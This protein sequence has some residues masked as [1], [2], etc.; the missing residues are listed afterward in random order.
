M[1]VDSFGTYLLHSQEKAK[2]FQQSDTTTFA[3][4]SLG[5]WHS[6]QSV[7][8]FHLQQYIL[9]THKNKGIHILNH[10]RSQKIDITDKVDS[11]L[12]I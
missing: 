8:T 5:L 3:L 1:S 11:T 9:K 4:V 6:Q 7:A 10:T 12:F 2:L